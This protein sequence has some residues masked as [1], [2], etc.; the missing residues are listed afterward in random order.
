METKEEKEDKLDNPLKNKRCKQE[1]HENEHNEKAK[2]TGYKTFFGQNIAS[3]IS[4]S[5]T[6]QDPDESFCAMSARKKGCFFAFFFVDFCAG[7]FYSLLGPFFPNEVRFVTRL[8]NDL[9]NRMY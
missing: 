1:E 3:S 7:T 8:C 6:H 5:Q 4:I 2:Y 9:I